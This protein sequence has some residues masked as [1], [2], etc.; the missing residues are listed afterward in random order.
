MINKKDNP[1]EWSI[2]LYELEDLADHST[3]L[4]EEMQTNPSYGEEEFAIDIGHLYAHLNRAWNSRNFNKE[5]TEDEW[6]KNTEFPSDI[7]PVG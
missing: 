5:P 3:K 2:L 1:V 6:Q 7:Q 4:I